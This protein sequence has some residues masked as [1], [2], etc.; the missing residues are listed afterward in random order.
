LGLGLCFLRKS[1]QAD[2]EGMRK[3]DAGGKHVDFWCGNID[4]NVKLEEHGHI[5]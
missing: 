5:K 4:L 2:Y 3:S 1:N